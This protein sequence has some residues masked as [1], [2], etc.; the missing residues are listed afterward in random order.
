MLRLG[1]RMGWLGWV[2][3]GV[4]VVSA[5]G[6]ALAAQSATSTTQAP[7]ASA[8]RAKAKALG[9]GAGWRHALG[10]RV[11]HG[12][13]S[14]EEALASYGAFSAR[15]ARA[16]GIASRLQRLIP[17]LPPRA[18]TAL[19]AVAGRERVCRRAFT[20][21]LEQAH[22]RLAAAGPARAAEPVPALVNGGR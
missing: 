14:R 16:F 5:G 18:L 22:P 10:R 13:A 6:A 20:W 4:L 21:Y 17:A 3:A 9:R 12:E 7:S 2:V 1:R 15:H 8:G 19:L 11:L